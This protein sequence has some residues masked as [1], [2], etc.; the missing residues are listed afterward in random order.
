MICVSPYKIYIHILGSCAA[1]AVSPG[2]AR[3]PAPRGAWWT[4]H[5]SCQAFSLPS[6]QA[7]T[8]GHGSG[9]GPCPA[10]QLTFSG[11]RQFHW[12][13]RC[14][15]GG[16]HRY[17]SKANSELGLKDPILLGRSSQEEVSWCSAPGGDPRLSSPPLSPSVSYR[18]SVGAPNR[19]ARPWGTGLSRATRT[20]FLGLT[21]HCCPKQ[22]KNK[23]KE[24]PCLWMQ[25]QDPPRRAVWPSQGMCVPKLSVHQIISVTNA[26]SIGFFFKQLLPNNNHTVQ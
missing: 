3:R 21:K 18:S 11:Y 26:A 23:D 24:Q 5:T 19:T 22:A 10:A 6:F 17:S 12:P 16:R 15:H 8:L 4:T 2:R 1:L 14:R 25:G 20:L 9:S 13:R 7:P